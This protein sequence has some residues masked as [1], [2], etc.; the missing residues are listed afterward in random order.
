MLPLVLVQDKY[1]EMKFGQVVFNSFF[2][3]IE[4]NVPQSQL[5]LFDSQWMEI[6]TSLLT[7]ESV[8]WCQITF[9]FLAS[10]ESF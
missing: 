6:H 10:V 9:S 1:T 4:K 5:E 2:I 3:Y 7:N 8:I